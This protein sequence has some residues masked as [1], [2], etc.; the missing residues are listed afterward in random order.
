VKERQKAKQT[1]QAETETVED[2][3]R[4][5]AEDFRRKPLKMHQPHGTKF[6]TS[7]VELAHA[8]ESAEATV[9]ESGGTCEPDAVARIAIVIFEANLR[10]SLRANRIAGEL[11][12]EERLLAAESGDRD[13]HWAEI[14][15]AMRAA[16]QDVSDVRADVALLAHGIKIA[17]RIARRETGG[18]TPHNIAEIAIQWYEGYR[19]QWEHEATDKHRPG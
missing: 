14:T 10:R 17:E 8:I 1:A 18:F 15:A 2:M 5:F 9:L 13:H 3:R 16:L 4:R 6:G 11:K 12:D 19:E 7:T